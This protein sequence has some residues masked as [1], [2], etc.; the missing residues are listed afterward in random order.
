MGIKLDEGEELT[1]IPLLQNLRFL[2]NLRLVAA[3]GEQSFS[4]IPLIA[5]HGSRSFLFIY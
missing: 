1:Q 5:A 3:H 2:R 4:Q